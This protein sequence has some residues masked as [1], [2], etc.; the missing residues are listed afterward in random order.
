MPRPLRRPLLIAFATGLCLAVAGLTA[1]TAGAVTYPATT[2]SIGLPSSAPWQ[3]SSAGVASVVTDAGDQV[4][5]LAG[6]ASG[7]G[8]LH[9]FATNAYPAIDNVLPAELPAFNLL[10]GA[11]NDQVDP[12]T[13]LTLQPSAPARVAMRTVSGT[14]QA[15]IDLHVAYAYRMSLG[16]VEKAVLTC[17]LT[18]GSAWST[19]DLNDCSS[20][21][22][23]VNSPNDAMRW[24]P[25]T[26]LTFKP[27]WSSTPVTAPAGTYLASGA[28]PEAMIA[29]GIGFRAVSGN[30]GAVLID[31]LSIRG[32]S[33]DF[34]A[35]GTTAALSAGAAVL[36]APASVT[37]TVT[38]STAAG[39]FAI[40]EGAT[41]LG[42]GAAA[43]GAFTF[44]TST[45]PVG[46]HALTAVFTPENDAEFTASTSPVATLTINV[47]ESTPAPPPAADTAGLEKFIENAGIDVGSATASFSP[48]VT[49]LDPTAPIS[50]T[51]PWADSSDSFVDVYGYS[52]PTFLGTFPVVDGAV[53]LTGLDVSA[54]AAGGHHLVF[55]G[56]TSASVQVMLITLAAILPATGADVAAPVTAAI[57]LIL[58]G[59]GSLAL[60]RRRRRA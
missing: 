12:A 45:L 58:L 54:L 29:T 23:T 46:A 1:T 13:G 39:S 14:A 25:T 36:G 4:L 52:T 53:Q 60:V 26:D 6:S 17:E 55:I 16:M 38:P 57:V 47:K 59:I 37:A 43:S 19:V 24:I 11:T 49:G 56:Q 3:E 35:A 40:F 31:D 41:K 9:G 42:A 30:S 51:L 20:L 34:S 28:R 32:Q 21:S 8:V 44:T 18:V 48:P 22:R 33:I 5:M 2:G 15:F 10:A 27:S 7:N 50:G